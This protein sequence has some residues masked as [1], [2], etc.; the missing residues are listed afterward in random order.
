M[1]RLGVV[2]IPVLMMC[3]LLVSACGS[4]S[5]AA[6]KKTG[7][8]HA[9]TKTS[10]ARATTQT[11]RIG[12]LTE[13]FDTPLPADPARASIVEGWRTAM[14]LWD[15]S[16]ENLMLMAPVTAYVTGSAL[17][18]LKVYLVRAKA[19]DV[20]PGGADRF[21]NTRVAVTSGTSSTITTCDDGSNF[22]E[23]NPGTGVPDPAYSASANQRYGS[24]TWQMILRG[25]HWAINAVSAAALPDSRAKPCQP[26]PAL[27]CWSAIRSD[28]LSQR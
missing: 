19:D 20:V 21:F 28:F 4:G 5:P 10:P 25:G 6:P 16:Q 7:P 14:I 12:R 22:E 1:G 23:V 24:A 2:I 26:L 13:I 11:V 18:G 17:H 15:K 3:G 8:A 27:N 9:T